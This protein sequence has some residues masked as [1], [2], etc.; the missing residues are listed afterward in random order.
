MVPLFWFVYLFFFFYVNFCFLIKWIFAIYGF[1]V[2]EPVLVG[3][4]IFRGYPE[5]AYSRPDWRKDLEMAF[6]FGPACICWRANAQSNAFLVWT[7][8][9]LSITIFDGQQFIPIKYQPMINCDSTKTCSFSCTSM[10]CWWET[11]WDIGL[12][13]HS[14]DE[15]ELDH[16]VCTLAASSISRMD[17]FSLIH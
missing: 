15:N 10:L 1:L 17:V 7:H 14:T 13:Y 9:F 11:V 8:R 4:R 3:S 2:P 5:S 6:T 16:K 12:N